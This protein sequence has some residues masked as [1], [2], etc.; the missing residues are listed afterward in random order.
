MVFYKYKYVVF[1]NMKYYNILIL[2]GI[3]ITLIFLTILYLRKIKNNQDKQNIKIKS[4]IKEQIYN[5]SSNLYKINMKNVNYELPSY[6]QETN[7]GCKMYK[8]LT[9]AIPTEFN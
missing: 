4:D 1:I 2:I 5:D 7:H 9:M 6:I 8:D 3:L